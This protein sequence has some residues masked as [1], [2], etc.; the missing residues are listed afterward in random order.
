MIPT[1]PNPQPGVGRVLTQ[2]HRNWLGVL[3][4]ICAVFL[5]IATAINDSF[6]VLTAPTKRA[7]GALIYIYHTMNKE[8]YPTFVNSIAWSKD[9]TYIAYATGDKL[10][11]V[12]Q[13]T[14]QR[15]VFVYHGHHDWVNNVVWSPDGKRIASASGDGTVH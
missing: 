4:V 3:I 5:L 10:V 6:P 8:I 13:P 11:Y 15:E 7:I 14:A 12:L 2:P 9:S 1:T